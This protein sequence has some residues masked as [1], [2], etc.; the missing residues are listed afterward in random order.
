MTTKSKRPTKI[1]FQ[2]ERRVRLRIIC[3]SPPNPEKHGATFG[4]QDNST[5]KECIRPGNGR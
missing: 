5:T 4:L 2:P 1:G 3:L